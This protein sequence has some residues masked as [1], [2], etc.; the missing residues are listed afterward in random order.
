MPPQKV[1][2]VQ[3]VTRLAEVFRTH[4]YE[5]ASLSLISQRTGLQRASLYHRFPEGKLQ[6][7][8]AVLDWVDERFIGHVLAPLS[9][10]GEPSQRVAETAKRLDGYFDGGRN[11]CLLDVLSLGD[12]TEALRAH[13]QLSLIHI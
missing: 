4:G 8:E 7:A 10:A 13:V 1:N 12:A 2:D 11:S 9:E 5:G 6:M 3:L